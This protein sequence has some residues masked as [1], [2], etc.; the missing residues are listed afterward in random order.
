MG[1]KYYSLGYKLPNDKNRKYLWFDNSMDAYTYYF[2]YSLFKKEPSCHISTDE[3]TIKR[4]EELVKRT[5][6]KIENLIEYESGEYHKLWL[7][8]YHHKKENSK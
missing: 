6:N 8:N 4:Y 5:K 3:K 1:K 2:C 7:E